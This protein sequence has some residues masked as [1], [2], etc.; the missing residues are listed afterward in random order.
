MGACDFYQQSP[1][2]NGETMDQA[3]SR[4]HEEAAWE[5]GHGGYTGTLAEK[6][7]YVTVDLPKGKTARW[8]H[9]AISDYLQI[10]WSNQPQWTGDRAEYDRAVKEAERLVQQKQDESEL[11][12]VLGI[13]KA[14]EVAEAWD[15]KWGP[16][17][18]CKDEHGWTFM[19]MASS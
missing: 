3:F 17:V 10:G 7:G 19:G 18:G 13:R 9:D 6:H 2:R 14:R 1:A 12:K 4:M 8:L 16:A 15:D 5:F 11:A